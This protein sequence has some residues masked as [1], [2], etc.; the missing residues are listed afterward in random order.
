MSVIGQI[1]NI[2]N[3]AVWQQPDLFMDTGFLRIV[4]IKLEKK[5]R[6]FPRE[7]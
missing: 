5:C 7:F 4:S 3:D 2:V 6:D 1:V